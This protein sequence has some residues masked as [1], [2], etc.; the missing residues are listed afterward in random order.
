MR[1]S[2]GSLETRDKARYEVAFVF[3]G[4]GCLEPWIHACERRCDVEV[5]RAGFGSAAS[6]PLGYIP[7]LA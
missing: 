7:P 2:S 4:A 3:A 1:N 5:V 6:I